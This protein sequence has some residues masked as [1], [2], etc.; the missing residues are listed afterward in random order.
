MYCSNLYK[1]LKK[2]E[3]SCAMPVSTADGIESVPAAPMLRF[4]LIG[5]GIS[6]IICG[7]SGAISMEYYIENDN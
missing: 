3:E 4:Y 7:I 2:N 5:W 1:K 6:I